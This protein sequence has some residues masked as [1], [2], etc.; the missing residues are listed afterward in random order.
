MY[1]YLVT[2][3][4]ASV[5]ATPTGC[6]DPTGQLRAQGIG[7]PRPTSG[8]VPVGFMLDPRT[9][10]YDTLDVRRPGT[11]EKDVEGTFVL[12]FADLVYDRDPR[13]HDQEPALFDS[14]DQSKTSETP[15]GGKQD[16]YAIE[17]KLTVTRRI[18]QV[19]AWLGVNAL[20]SLNARRN[21]LD[22]LPVWWRLRFHPQ[23]CDVPVGCPGSQYGLRASIR[24]RGL[25]QRR[26][27]ALDQ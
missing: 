13:L 14:M 3:C 9:T 7:G 26:W 12:A 24:E 17:N 22:G 21:L 8:Y 20:A 18:T 27:C 10:G 1:N 6:P 5:T 4:G 19:P 2:N 23:R 11:F 15:S 16:V 25:S